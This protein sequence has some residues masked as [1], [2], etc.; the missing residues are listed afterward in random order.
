MFE[1]RT[2]IIGGTALFTYSWVL[3]MKK[4]KILL[5]RGCYITFA[6]VIGDMDEKGFETGALRVEE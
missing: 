3:A 2:Y 4:A 1:E 6:E 5:V